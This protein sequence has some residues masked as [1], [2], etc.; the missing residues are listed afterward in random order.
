[1]SY[2]QKSYHIYQKGRQVG[3]A[4]RIGAEAAKANNPGKV[5]IENR[6]LEIVN[7]TN[8][9][10][11]YH[12]RGGRKTIR[13]KATNIHGYDDKDTLNISPPFTLKVTRHCSSPGAEW[14]TFEIQANTTTFLVKNSSECWL[15]F[16]VPE[17]NQGPRI[18]VAL[19]LKSPLMCSEKTDN[20]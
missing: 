17:S 19:A 18:I 10:V 20:R 7:T 8:F 9:T 15:G 3:K 14:I 11:D 5:K 6:E 13:P 16:D 1:M 12:V 2:H 4:K